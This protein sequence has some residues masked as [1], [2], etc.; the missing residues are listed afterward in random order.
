M[1][2]CT[3]AKSQA[4]AQRTVLVG[5]LTHLSS[6]LQTGCPRS[7]HRARL[8]LSRLDG[9]PECDAQT[10]TSVAAL[11]EAVSQICMPSPCA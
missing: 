7:L 6:Y 10:L 3:H 4:A 2:P 9:K 1:Q 11:E 5:T 8:L